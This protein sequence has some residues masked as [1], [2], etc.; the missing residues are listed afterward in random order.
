MKANATVDASLCSPQKCPVTAEVDPTDL[1]I[2]ASGT[3]QVSATPTAL[4]LP[5]FELQDK[6]V[7]RVKLPDVTLRGTDRLG[8]I[9]GALLGS[10][11]N[12]ID[13]IVG[14]F[15]N[16]GSLEDI[17]KIDISDLKIEVEPF[18]TNLGRIALHGIAEDAQ[19]T[20]STIKVDL[21]ALDARALFQ[22]LKARLKGCLILNGA[23][24]SCGD[25]D[26]PHDDK[27]VDNRGSCVTPAVI[28]VEFVKEGQ[29]II[30]LGSNFGTLPGRLLVMDSA[31]QRITT[32]QSW[33]NN[34]IEALPTPLIPRGSHFLQ[35]QTS[36]GLMSS[37]VPF[38]ID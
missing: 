15:T 13:A 4:E 5:S 34:R 23:D 38:R 1:H 12:I 22:G 9:V 37:A 35:V 31:S 33:A 24:G 21:D 30:V 3:P 18:R 10:Q 26:S 28:R 29:P 8:G 36:N 17:A 32:I 19:H 27:Y 25:T 7:V 2:T 16:A 11:S 14:L 20:K 6:I